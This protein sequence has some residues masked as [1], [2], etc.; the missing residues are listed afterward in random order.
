LVKETNRELQTTHGL[1][2]T[3]E[4]NS[5]HSMKQRCINP[6]NKDYDNYGGRGIKVCDRWLNSF[7]NFLIDMGPKPSENHSLDRYP[8]TNGHY[9]FNNCRWATSIEQC[10]NRRNNVFFN[11][12]GKKYTVVQISEE[13]NINSMTFVNRINRGWSVEE[14]IETPVRGYSCQ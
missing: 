13:F 14:A 2:N 6:D 8:D 7:E 3:P 1:S 11:Y 5:W 9:E 4:Y 10:N 12:K